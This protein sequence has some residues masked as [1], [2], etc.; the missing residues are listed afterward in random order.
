MNFCCCCCCSIGEN[1]GHTFRHCVTRSPNGVNLM[2]VVS[3]DLV[4]TLPAVIE[5]E[6]DRIQELEMLFGCR[7]AQHELAT[8]TCFRPVRRALSLALL[9][10]VRVAS[11]TSQTLQLCKTFK[12]SVG[13]TRRNIVIWRKKERK[14]ER[15]KKG[16]IHLTDSRSLHVSFHV[17]LLTF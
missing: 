6:S 1:V 5:R 10:F 9:L 4:R 12:P 17:G 13:K 15:E 16:F 8:I 2:R 7:L 14:K 11:R 3:E